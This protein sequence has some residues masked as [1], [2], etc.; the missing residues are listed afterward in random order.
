MNSSILSAPAR[1]I[2]GTT[3]TSTSAR[4]AIGSRAPTANNA[5]APPI[6]APTNAGGARKVAATARKSDTIA[7]PE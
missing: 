7:A 4:A 6:D 3:S 1:S 5:V 2:C